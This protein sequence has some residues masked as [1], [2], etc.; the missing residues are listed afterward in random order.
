MILPLK[1]V[2]CH[3]Y[4][5]SHPWIFYNIIADWIYGCTRRRVFWWHQPGWY[6][7]DVRLLLTTWSTTYIVLPMNI[8]TVLLYYFIS[9]ISLVA[10]D[11]CA[12]FTDIIHGCFNDSWANDDVIKRKHFPRNWP[13]VWEIH[14]S[15]VNSPHKGEWRGALIFSLICVWRNGWVNNG[16]AGDL[17]RHFAHYDITVI[18]HMISPGPMQG[19]WMSLLPST[20]TQ[21]KKQSKLCAYLLKCTVRFTTNK[22]N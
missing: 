7:C 18:N 9:A 19:S 2:S 17:R 6:F 10:R 22:W 20:N 12:S 14:R 11:P 15:L 5:E 1:L 13:F 16:E 4:I 8:H 3:R 21:I